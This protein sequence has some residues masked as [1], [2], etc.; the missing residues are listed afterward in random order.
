LYFSYEGQRAPKET[1][2]HLLLKR[3]GEQQRQKH[4]TKELTTLMLIAAH[5][6]IS[7]VMAYK[8]SL[9]ETQIGRIQVSPAHNRIVQR[10]G[11]AADA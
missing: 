1:S 2:S 3:K 6:S 7:V 9:K 4:A 8:F 11:N 10:T 5:L